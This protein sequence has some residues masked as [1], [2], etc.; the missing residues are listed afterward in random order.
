MGFYFVL[1]MFPDVIICPIGD[2]RII[3]N[4]HYTIDQSLSSNEIN[5]SESKLLE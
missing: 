2:V 3:F 5:V 1:Q 4:L